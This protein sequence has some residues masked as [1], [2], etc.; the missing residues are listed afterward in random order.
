MYNNK[1]MQKYLTKAGSKNIRKSKIGDSRIQVF[2]EVEEV[3]RFIDE[4]FIEEALQCT[5]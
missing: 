1:S 4:D 2:S 5:K 3:H